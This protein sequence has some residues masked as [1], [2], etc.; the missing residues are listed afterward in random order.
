MSV[1][2]SGAVKWK[3]VPTDL[4]GPELKIGDRAPSDFALVG[5]DM[6]V[7]TGADLAG[8]PRIFC[9]VPSLDTA[10]CDV[11]MRRFNAEAE[12]LPGVRVISVSL[13]LP[14]ALKRWCGA[15]GS[16]R[17]QAASDWK[18]RAFGRAYGVLAPSKALLARAVFVVGA[19]DVV[20]HVEYVADVT[21]EPSYDAA[22]AA[23][24]ALD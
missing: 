5:A 6:S 1:I 11:E 14:F 15:T 24:R 16:E 12:K 19:D 7:I 4:E 17:I 10:V 23:A 22:L 18:E 8:K 9:A 21:R 3:D 20:R 13:D 2:R